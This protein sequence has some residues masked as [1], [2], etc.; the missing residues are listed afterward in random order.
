MV[1]QQDSSE[2]EYT[3]EMKQKELQLLAETEDINELITLTQSKDDTVR[4]K[5]T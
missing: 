3:F 1:K 4:L 2:D 5:A